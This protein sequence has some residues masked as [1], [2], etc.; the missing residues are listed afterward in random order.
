MTPYE[1]ERTQEPRLDRARARSLCGTVPGAEGSDE[2]CLLYLAVAPE[3]T[4]VAHGTYDHVL[5]NLGGECVLMAVS[6]ENPDDPKARL[7]EIWAPV[8][9]HIP[10]VTGPIAALAGAPGS[11]LLFDRRALLAYRDALAAY[12]PTVPPEGRV[13]LKLAVWTPGIGYV[14]RGIATATAEDLSGT[15]TVTWPQGPGRDDVLVGPLYWDEVL[16]DLPTPPGSQGWR[17][18]ASR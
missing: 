9:L 18:C 13:K 5:P 2:G 1:L 14:P 4:I 8:P 12:N 11:P 15:H 16:Y 7:D 10:G 6:S 3:G 17:R